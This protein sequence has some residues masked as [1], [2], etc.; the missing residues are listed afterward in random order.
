M[1]GVA[2]IGLATHSW[3]AEAAPINYA[4]A[5]VAVATFSSGKYVVQITGSFTIDPDT[6]TESNVNL[7]LTSGDVGSPIINGTY[8]QIDPIAMPTSTSII[9]TLAGVFG[10]PYTLE[11]QWQP[12]LPSNS[13]PPPTLIFIGSKYN[14]VPSIINTDSET[15]F[16]TLAGQA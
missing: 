6:L 15:L 13:P 4:T 1:A 5:G 8:S 7:S 14:I 10:V 11:L 3:V 9:A 12:L 16:G 2:A